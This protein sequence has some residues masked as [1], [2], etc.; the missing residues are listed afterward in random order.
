M[1]YGKRF[2]PYYA[3]VIRQ[4]SPHTSPHPHPD[5]PITTPSSCS[6][7]TPRR[8]ILTEQAPKTDSIDATVGGIDRDGTGA[9][10]SFDPVG[11]YERES[12]RAAGSAQS[13]IQPFLDNMVSS[14]CFVIQTLSLTRH[15]STGLR[16]ESD[17]RSSGARV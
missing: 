4:Y 13:L 6:I 12:C 1:L 17:H 15:A 10:Y 2:F 11:S 3:Y 7:P 16:K 9:V 8:R 14:S 5:H